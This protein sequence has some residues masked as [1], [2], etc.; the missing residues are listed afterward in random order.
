MTVPTT[1][2]VAAL[3]TVTCGGLVH[4][5]GDPC[6]A[7]PLPEKHNVLGIGDAALAAFAIAVVQGRDAALVRHEPK[8]HGTCR[9]IDGVYDE[10]LPCV[11]FFSND[12]DQ[13]IVEGLGLDVRQWTRVPAGQGWPDHLSPLPARALPHQP[14]H[15]FRDCAELLVDRTFTRSSGELAD[16]YFETLTPAHTYR[17]AAAFAAAQQGRT[18]GAAVGV[19]WGGAYLAAAV[20]LSLGLPLLMAD[21]DGRPESVDRAPAAEPVLLVDDLVNTGRAFVRCEPLLAAAGLSPAGRT[22]LFALG[23]RSPAACGE[24]SVAARLIHEELV[25]SHSHTPVS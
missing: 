7:Q 19:R 10:T 12:A 21:P 16:Y 2:G 24:V 14:V 8:D 11:V 9:Q 3:R 20:A 6:D 4:L 22:A 5:L 23:R 17:V 15:D 1:A 18:W 25:V 13:A